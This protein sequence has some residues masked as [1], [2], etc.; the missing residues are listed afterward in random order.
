MIDHSNHSVTKRKKKAGRNV[1][2]SC[3]CIIASFMLFIIAAAAPETGVCGLS[4]ILDQISSRSS[5]TAGAGG[6]SFSSEEAGTT[7]ETGSGHSEAVPEITILSDGQETSPDPVAAGSGS[8][9]DDSWKLILVN[10]TH[11][12]PEGYEIPE[13]TTLSGGFQV[14][15]RIYPALQQMFDDARS[16]GILPHITS[17]Y[18]TME[19]QQYQMDAKTQEYLSSGYSQEEARALAEEWVAIPG[20]SEHQ[21]GI[22]VDISSVE[23]DPGAVWY[24]LNM[25]AWQYGFIQRYP[26]EKYAITGINTEPWHYRYVGT[27]A[28]RDMHESGQCL[29]E[30]LGMA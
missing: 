25:Y 15:S 2:L 10:R 21:L 18:R 14:D 20:T 6:S 29:E 23:Q 9:A 5:F 24:W 16:Q 27:E 30:Y 4:F 17:A 7:P 22:C 28:A 26:D 11:P 12:I 1:L 8:S 13:L 3:S 19:D